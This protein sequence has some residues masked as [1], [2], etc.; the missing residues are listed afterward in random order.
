MS[1]RVFEAQALRP[2]LDPPQAL[3]GK[4]RDAVAVA[5]TNIEMLQ[6]RGELSPDLVPRPAKK[7]Q[8]DVVSEIDPLL[9]KKARVKQTSMQST[10]SYPVKQNAASQRLLD[11]I[12]STTSQPKPTVFNPQFSGITKSFLHPAKP[13]LCP[14]GV[15][16]YISKWLESISIDPDQDEWCRPD[17]H[18]EDESA[19]EELATRRR[20]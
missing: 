2:R 7:R 10:G 6:A 9:S 14:D 16:A 12:V 4:L 13:S 20:G 8:L 3:Q 15:H 17:S 11:K 5:G 19:L 18:L 1:G